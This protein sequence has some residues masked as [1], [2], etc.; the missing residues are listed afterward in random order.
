M[1]GTSVSRFCNQLDVYF[2]L[3]ELNGDSKHFYVTITLLEGPAYTW[4][5]VQGVSESW[6]ALKAGMLPYFKPADNA[7]KT[8][9]GAR[10]MDLAG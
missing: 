1:D 7:F 4:Y 6:R 9:L 2:K 5:S 10:K 3:V 8:L